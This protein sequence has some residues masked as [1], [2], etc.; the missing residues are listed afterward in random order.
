MVVAS[1]TIVTKDINED[2]VL[3]SGSPAKIVKKY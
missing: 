1:G 2:Y 3:V